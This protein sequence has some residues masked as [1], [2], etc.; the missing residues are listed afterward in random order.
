MLIHDFLKNHFHQDFH[1]EKTNLGLTNDIYTTT[2]NGIK[3]AVRV[4][5]DSLGDSSAFSNEATALNLIQPLQLDAEEI[6]YHPES[7]VRITRWI[8]HAQEFSEYPNKE[9]GVIRVASLLK[10]LHQ[11]Q[12]QSGCRFDGIALLQEYKSKIITPLYDY[13]SFDFILDSVEKIKNPHV[14]CHNDVVSGN[15]L[16]TPEKDYLIDYEYSKDNDP[17]FDIMSFFTENRITEP[18]LRNLFY[19]H[20]FESELST[21]QKKDLE[22]YE[23]FHNYLW[24]CWANMMYDL[25]HEEV[26][27]NIAKDKYFALCECIKK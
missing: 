10:R 21:Q 14:L 15:I 18:H 26:Y 3:V 12:L 20:Y 16:F 11:A 5:K 1:L 23:Q 7:R 13:T 17:L 9:D 25:L 27:L 24:C 22:S 8:A 6:F 2:L 4:V 19:Q